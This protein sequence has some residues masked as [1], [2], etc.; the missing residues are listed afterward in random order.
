MSMDATE[1][2]VAFN[3][4]RPTRVRYKVVGLAVL[5]GMVTYLDRVCISQVMPNI[6][7]DLSLSEVQKGYVFSVFALSYALFALPAARWADRMGTRLLLAGI[8]VWWSLFTM[9]TALAW[10]FASLLLIRFLFG[11]GEAGAWPSIARTF[12]SWIPLKE[13]GTVQGIFFS[14][15]HLTG[16]LTPMLVTALLVF[17]SWRVIFVGFG[18]LGFIWAAAWYWW[19]RDNPAGHPEV[20]SQE[21]ELIVREQEKKGPSQEVGWAYWRRLFQSSN[22]LALCV[23]Y[24]SN[25]FLLYFCITDLPGYLKETRG[26]GAAELAFFT[27]LPLILS[28][29]GDLFGGVVTDWVTVRFGLRTGRCG[30][31]G[32]AYLIAGVSMLLVPTCPWSTGAAVLIALAAA[33]TMFTLASAWGTCID[34]GG[35]NAGVVSAAMNT[36]GQIGSFLCPLIVAYSLTWFHRNWNISIYLMGI[37]FLIGAACWCVI[38]PTQRIFESGELKMEPAAI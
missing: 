12:A 37:L 32:V 8:V 29:F 13:R 24:F 16:G 22:L 38:N 36:S 4:T 28:I 34:I 33:A 9:G 23:M 25:S 35:K 27:G 3:V 14:G 17:T 2:V 26:F 5:L 21:V 30:V 6:M 18:M 1:T 19:F 11:A 7:V 15:A 31:G 20:N 10:G